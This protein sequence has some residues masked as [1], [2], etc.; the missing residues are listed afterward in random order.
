MTALKKQYDDG[1]QLVMQQC[2]H[3][4]WDRFKKK[5]VTFNGYEVMYLE[6]DTYDGED[7]FNVVNTEY[8]L[9]EADARAA[10][11]IRVEGTP[12]RASGMF[13]GRMDV[14]LNT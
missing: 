6:A 9:N 14:L 11:N 4:I 2:S 5:M 8:F 1:S 10:F 3:E 12:S 13:T 7:C